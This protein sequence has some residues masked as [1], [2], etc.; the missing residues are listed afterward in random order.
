LGR[1]PLKR[2]KVTLFAVIFYISENNI[3][4]IRSF[5]RP[6]FCHSIVMKYISSLLQ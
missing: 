6:L 5:C 2:K 4:D 3:H 1:S